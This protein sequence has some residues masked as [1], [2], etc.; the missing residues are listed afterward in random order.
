MPYITAQSAVSVLIFMNIITLFAAIELT[1]GFSILKF[2]GNTKIT[3]IVGFV[4]IM[5]INYFLFIKDKK[6][7]QIA[8]EFEEESKTE[9]RIKLILCW[10]YVI[11]SHVILFSV[12]SIL[13]LYKPVK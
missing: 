4:I 13:S 3:A 6:Y 11:F 7:L 8:K 1:T 12:V 10:I 9:Q 2:L 5:G